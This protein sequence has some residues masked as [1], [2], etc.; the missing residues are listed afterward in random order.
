MAKKLKA[1][2]LLE[3]ERKEQLLKTSEVLLNIEKDMEKINKLLKEADEVRN[4]L[5]FFSFSSF[6][7]SLFSLFVKISYKNLSKPRFS[8]DTLEQNSNFLL[9]FMA[10]S[11]L[12]KLF[13]ELEINIFT[14]IKYI[15][16]RL[17]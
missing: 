7:S 13:L 2:R 9:P 10:A 17:N 15:K 1:K 12:F 6:L 8:L 16:E 3:Q 11:L 4:L 14:S 5:L